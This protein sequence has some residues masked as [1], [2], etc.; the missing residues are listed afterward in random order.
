[1]NVPQIMS[2]GG[3]SSP[4]AALRY[5]KLVAQDAIRFFRETGD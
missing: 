4:A 3:W 5:I 1:M 2:V